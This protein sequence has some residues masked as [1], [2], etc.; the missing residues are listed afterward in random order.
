[1]DAAEEVVDERS[2]LEV[3]KH[4]TCVDQEGREVDVEEREEAYIISAHENH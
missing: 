4:P 1:M 3:E 2:E